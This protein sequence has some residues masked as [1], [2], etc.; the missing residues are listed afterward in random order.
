MVPILIY[1]SINEPRAGH[2]WGVLSLPPKVF[3]AQMAHVRRSGMNPITLEAAQRGLIEPGTLPSRPVVITL[4]DG[5]LDNWLF[6]LPILERYEIPATIFPPNEMIDRRS[7][8]RPREGVSP[9]DD[10]SFGF[11]TFDELRAMEATGLVRVESHSTTHGEITSGPEILDFHHPRGDAYWI[12]WQLYPERKP[13]WLSADF[14]AE[15]PLG[16]PVYRHTYAMV[17]RRWTPPEEEGEA[18]RALVEEAGGAV[19]FDRDDWREL[20]H[21]AARDAA[22][23]DRDDP[24]RRESPEAYRARVLADMTEGRDELE[25]E[26]GHPVRFLCWPCGLFNDTTRALA[27]EAGY[28]A[29]L[30]CEQHSNRLR[31]DPTLLH[32]LYFGQ[33][34]RY[35]RIRTDALLNL[36]FRGTL[37]SAHGSPLGKVMT[38]VANRLMGA[39]SLLA[40]VDS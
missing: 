24:S 2:V 33:D 8:S 23:D 32:R 34:E 40:A 17:E 18:C 19:F 39:R 36:R 7:G 28:T 3:E 11:V 16:T 37:K 4:D 5:Y 38:V 27:A 10:A 35:L 15:I 9:G 1:H 6:A 20:L 13:H 12:H 21:V 25:R 26:L 22:P 30:T 29:T 31:Q 14:S